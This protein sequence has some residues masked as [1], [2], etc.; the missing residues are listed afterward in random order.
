MLNLKRRN[1]TVASLLGGLFLV[2]LQ[3]CSKSETQSEPERVLDSSI[4][5]KEGQRFLSVL[6]SAD[7]VVEDLSGK[8]LSIDQVQLDRAWN[9]TTCKSTVKNIGDTP[10]RPKKHSALR[11]DRAWIFTGYADLR[12][13]LPDAVSEWWHT[14]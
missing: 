2:A 4:A 5:S 10:L 3:G 13:R 9:G 8:A 12:G 6:K 14:G 1:V 11:G 7:W